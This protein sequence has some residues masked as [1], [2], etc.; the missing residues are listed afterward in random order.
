MPDEFDFII[1]QSKHDTACGKCLYYFGEGDLW[2]LEDTTCCNR[3]WSGG[4]ECEEG[5]E[6]DDPDCV[7]PCSDD[8]PSGGTSHGCDGLPTNPDPYSH[9]TVQ[10]GPEG[11]N[12]GNC[13][14]AGG[15]GKRCGESCSRTNCDGLCWWEYVCE[16]D[17][18][19]YSTLCLEGEFGGCIWEWM[20]G[21][22][23]EGY[24]S[25]SLDNWQIRSGLPS[26]RAYTTCANHS[27]LCKC[28]DKPEG[29]PD[30]MNAG[31]PCEQVDNPWSPASQP[32]HCYSPT[33]VKDKWQH[34]RTEG[35]CF[36]T[37]G[38]AKC[39]CYGR[40]PTLSDPTTGVE[41]STE[42]YGNDCCQNGTAPY[43]CPTCSE[44]SWTCI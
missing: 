6:T 30:L 42:C 27:Y 43:S 18:N 4:P 14:D 7:C 10:C 33:I 16:V 11:P 15:V 38:Q 1:V 17:L 35:D 2:Y 39:N 22:A 13:N 31:Q 19:D 32:G 3:D 36:Y 8:Y 41:Y 29:I 26:C 23:G 20:P 25:E 40:E 37:S 21:S 24:C 28:G 9:H 34:K 5:T 12:P 44:S